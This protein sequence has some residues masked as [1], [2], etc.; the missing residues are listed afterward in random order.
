MYMI[1]FVDLTINK[2]I[3]S[4]AIGFQLHVVRL[5]DMPGPP[6]PGLVG[7]VRP[8]RQNSWEVNMGDDARLDI[9]IPDAQ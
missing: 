5:N 1:D 7:M 6:Q 3:N 4:R 8:G 9:F 2:A